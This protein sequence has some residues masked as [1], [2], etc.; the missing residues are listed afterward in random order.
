MIA[1]VI[2]ILA[3][4]LKGRGYIQQPNGLGLF[5]VRNKQK[6][7]VTYKGTE[8]HWLLDNFTTSCIFIL[9]GPVS[10]TQADNDVSCGA[11]LTKRIPLRLFVYSNDNTQK[12]AS[13]FLDSLADNV[14]GTLAFQTNVTLQQQFSARTITMAVTSQEFRREIVWEQ[15][16]PGQQLSISDYQQLF[17]IDFDLTIEADPKCW[18]K[19]CGGMETEGGESLTNEQNEQIQP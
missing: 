8:L 13:P 2:Q 17:S 9:N 19:I 7:L 4:N 1:E 3:N 18:L 14:I 15:V 11:M 12:Q 16:Y 6:I 5:T 10:V